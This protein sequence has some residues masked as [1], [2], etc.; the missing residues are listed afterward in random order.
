MKISTNIRGRLFIMKKLWYGIAIAF[1]LVIAIWGIIG[2]GGLQKTKGTDDVITIVT[3]EGELIGDAADVKVT[4]A[5]REEFDRTHPNIKVIRRSAPTGEERKVFATAMAG[6]TAPDLADIPGVDTRT[7]IEQGFADDMTDLIRDWGEIDNIYPNMLQPVLKDGK[8]YGLPR[9]Y[10]I[11][12]LAYR[13]DLFKQVGLDPQEPPADWNEMIE[14]AKVLTNRAENRYGFGMMGMDFCAW[15]FMAGGDFMR[16]DPKTK[17]MKAIFDEKPGVTALQF[18]KDLRWKHNVIQNNVLQDVKELV[19]D[20]V[21]GRSAM[22]KFYAQD[23][24]RLLSQG[25]TAEQIGLAPLPAGPSGKSVSQMAPRVYIINPTI[26]P[27]KKRAAFE[28]IKYNVSKEAMIKRWKLQE[29]YGVLAPA[30]PIW[31]GLLQSEH[32]DFPSQWSTAIEEQS[33]YSRPEP[34]FPYWDKVKQYLVQPIQAVLL[35]KNADPA[36]EMKACA[37]K[38]QRE[39]FDKVGP[40]EGF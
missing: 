22:Y 9:E 40:V 31:K 36:K 39:L 20:F 26:S 10:Y 23:M 21:T 14:Y 27:E 11:M 38:V 5:L 1:I 16:V 30:T 32:V 25:L 8:Y 18:Y 4:R 29:K 17:V 15:H 7:Y 3:W 37:S 34:F 35:N 2:R 12:L 33:K 6:G 13:T 19:S 24:P 28:Y